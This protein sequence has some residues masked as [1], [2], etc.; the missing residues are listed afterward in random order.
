MERMR[1]SLGIVSLLAVLSPAA[2]AQQSPNYRLHAVAF[3]HASG[4]SSSAN[5]RLHEI[6]TGQLAVGDTT[7]V[8]FGARGGFVNEQ[9]FDL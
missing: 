2:D 9:V 3:T 6:A 7:G 4:E 5:Y 1:A 8:Q